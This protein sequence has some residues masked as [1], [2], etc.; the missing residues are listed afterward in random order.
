M[1]EILK[2]RNISKTFPGVLALQ[3]ISFDLHE[4]EVHCLCGE[5]GAGKST[6]I[7][8]LSGA[9][10]P[11]EGGEIFFEGQKVILTPLYAMQ[12]GIQTI[13]QEHV[14]FETLS[15]VENIFTGSEIVK[16]GLLQKKEMRRQTVEVLKYLKSDLSPEMKMGEL[17]S[18]EQ[19]IVEIAKGLVFKRKVIILD[20]P[21]ASFSS[22]EIENLLDIIQTIKNSGLGIIYI[23]HH[24]EEVFKIGDTG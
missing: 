19:K 8:I 17:S 4:G 12:M 18:G 10:Q 24:L 13:Y 16:R 20:E 21:T 9:Y 11:D 1:S 6:L 23:S 22:T 7:K 2:L 14:V 15:I 3:S 5:N